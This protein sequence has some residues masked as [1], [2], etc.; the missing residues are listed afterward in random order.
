METMFRQAETVR[1]LIED[2]ENNFDPIGSELF[3]W[4]G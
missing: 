3:G 2:M 4:L 1:K